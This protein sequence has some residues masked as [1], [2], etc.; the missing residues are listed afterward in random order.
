MAKPIDTNIV[1][2]TDLYKLTGYIRRNDG[3][4]LFNKN[5]WI[6]I[7]LEAVYKIF[8]I[9]LFNLLT[10]NEILKISLSNKNCIKDNTCTNLC[11]IVPTVLNGG[12]NVTVLCKNGGAIG[13]FIILDS[14]ELNTISSFTFNLASISV[15]GDYEDKPSK[16]KNKIFKLI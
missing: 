1:N 8:F 5:T 7:N 3:N 2:E 16:K 4:Y 11:G 12:G 10:A 15:Y 9:D 14:F 6:S 13:Q